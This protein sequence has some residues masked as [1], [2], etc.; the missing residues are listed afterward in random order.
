MKHKPKKT[1]NLVSDKSFKNEDSVKLN[2]TFEGAM[3]KA[4]S[5]PLTKKDKK[6]HTI[7]LQVDVLVTTENKG[8]YGIANSDYLIT[9]NFN[10][11]FLSEN[12]KQIAYELEDK[13]ISVMHQFCQYIVY[14]NLSNKPG[15]SQIVF[16]D[17]ENDINTA[18]DIYNAFTKGNFGTISKEE[19]MQLFIVIQECYSEVIGLAELISV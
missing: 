16:F 5:T 10:K 7:K 15:N 2:M 6:M 9:G 11:I 12:A 4:L 1:I 18:L 3:K 17:C 14:S 13:D 19:F 8:T